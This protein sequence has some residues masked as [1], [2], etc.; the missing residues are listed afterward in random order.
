MSDTQTRTGLGPP[1]CE[2]CDTRQSL[3]CCDN[4]KAAFFC[5]N[6]IQDANRGPHNKQCSAVQKA[7]E[8]MQEE[9]R[10]V[11]EHPGDFMTLANPFET[12]V[13]HFWDLIDTRD[14]MRA[15]FGL[16]EELPKLDNSTAVASALDHLTDM[17]RL[18][19]S[20]NMGLRDKVPALF[21]RLGR[22]QECYDFM[23]WWT[24]PDDGYDWGD[25][26]LP[27]LSI[28][29]ADA[30]E[31]PGNFCGQYDGLGHTV[32]LTLFK[33]RLLLHV[34][35]MDGVTIGIGPL[36]PQQIIDQIRREITGSDAIPASLIHQRNLLPV[37]ASLRAQ[38][39]Q[40]LDAV[41]DHNKFFWDMLINPGSN[42]TAQPYAYSRGSVE[43]AQLALKH[44]YSSWIET[45]GAIAIIEES[46]AA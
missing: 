20:D 30:L 24:T 38:V 4:C 7:L 8:H 42:L 31:S 46:R 6:H 10:A 37:I 13:G 22:D 33:I 12:G 35:A 41:H 34:Q 5:D 40:L 17:L 43:E 15:R 27:H 3:A 2:S 45:P 25:T 21:L 29:G 19:R 44:N 14:Y 1:Q 18:N 11:R 9:E 16:V 28:H 36:V 23:K 39:K 32:P 26:T